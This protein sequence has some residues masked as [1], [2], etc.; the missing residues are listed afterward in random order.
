MTQTTILDKL[1]IILEVSK[2]SKLFIGVIIFIILLALVALTTTRK[3]AKRGK[4]IYG[5]AYATVLVAILV[6]YHDSLGKMFDYMMNNFFIVLYFPNIAVY[7][8]AIIIANIILLVSVF[9]FKTPKLVKTINVIVYAIIHYLLALVLNVI[10]KNDLDIFSQISIYGNAEA[11]AIIEFSSAIFMVWM[12]F[13]ILYKMIRKY[14]LKGKEPVKRKVIVKKVRTLPEGISEV[15]VPLFVKAQPRKE[16]PKAKTEDPV[17]IASL[18]DE[19]KLEKAALEQQLEEAAEKLR[20]AEEQLKIQETTLKIKAEESTKREEEFNTK[21]Q[22]AEEQ[23]KI[24]EETIRRKVK[25]NSKL[26]EEQTNLQYE[27]IALQQ[28]KAKLQQEKNKLQQENQKLQDSKVEVLETKE[29][30]KVDATV[31]IM[32]NLDN[33][34]T[35]EDYKILATILKDKQK[36][37]NEQ[38][39]R[40][41]IKRQEQLKFASIHEAY[42]S[43]R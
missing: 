7:L 29:T 2:S 23:I 12:V 37:K 6:L 13:L 3:N 5:L 24:H 8:A 22:L 43:T 1:K 18:V 40:E 34:F 26:E 38:K 14:Q 4:F 16:E 28:E 11:Q 32:Q 33:M 36:K 21:L 15:P 35:L 9:G 17:I 31:A 19:H 41:E 10:T 27:Q 42:R 25:E 30:P 39:L 20:L